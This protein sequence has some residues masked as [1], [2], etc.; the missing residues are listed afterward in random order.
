METKTDWFQRA[1]RLLVGEVVGFVLLA[2]VLSNLGVRTD[3]LWVALL[4][5][6]LVPA[7]YFSRAAETL[8][9]SPVWFGVLAAL[10]PPGAFRAWWR[11]RMARMYVVPA[12]AMNVLPVVGEVEGFEAVGDGDLS[13][14]FRSGSL[15]H[16]LDFPQGAMPAL[17]AYAPTTGSAIDHQK[18]V[19][20]LTWAQA[21]ELLERVRLVIDAETRGVA[22]FDAMVAMAARDGRVV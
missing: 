9:M 13:V 5:F 11:L 14:S 20:P 4:V 8:G 15:M 12:G 1:Q 10:G 6:N 2:F 19:L 7:W 16:V 18:A 22:V 3:W 21:R 17:S